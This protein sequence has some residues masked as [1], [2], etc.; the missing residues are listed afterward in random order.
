VVAPEKLLHKRKEKESDSG[1]VLD[2]NL[3][4]LK[5]EVKS[6]DDLDFDINFEHTLFKSRSKSYLIEFY[7]MR[8]NFNPSLL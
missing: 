8:R 2:G 5:D 1:I 6:I 4:L 3:S 7:L